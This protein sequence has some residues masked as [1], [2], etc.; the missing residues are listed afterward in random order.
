MIQIVGNQVLG[1]GCGRILMLCLATSV[2]IAVFGSALAAMG[3]AV[4]FTMAM[5]D[6]G[7]VP[8]L[9]AV[10]NEAGMPKYTLRCVTVVSFLIGTLGAVGGSTTMLAV[11]TASN[12]G[13]F[14]LYA[15]VCGLCYLS[16][17]GTF[18][19]EWSKHVLIPCIGAALNLTLL[20][21]ILGIGYGVGGS[22]REATLIAFGVAGLWTL[23]SWSL[24][25]D[26]GVVKGC[27]DAIL[28]E[29]GAMKS[30]N[31]S[32]V[33]LQNKDFDD[34]QQDAFQGFVDQET[35]EVPPTQEP[36][37]PTETAEPKNTGSDLAEVA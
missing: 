17:V 31:T 4:R 25:T 1:A 22:T 19:Y 23:I 36:T 20:A 9:F 32:F 14:V 16:Y 30:R 35:G 28:G 3:T 21:A 2:C 24:V 10:Q 34:L 37:A 8:Q 27:R 29:G 13:T 26:N 12:M 18:E 6:D 11:S 5:A 33:A 7:V 15:T